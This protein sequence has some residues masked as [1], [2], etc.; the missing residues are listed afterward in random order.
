MNKGKWK[1]GR[2]AAL[3]VL[4]LCLIMVTILGNIVQA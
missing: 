2:K 3:G 4:V 1:H